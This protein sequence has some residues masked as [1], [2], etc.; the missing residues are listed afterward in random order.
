MNPLWVVNSGPGIAWNRRPTRNPTVRNNILRCDR[1]VPILRIDSLSTN[2]NG[3]GQLNRLKANPVQLP[4]VTRQRFM[5]AIPSPERAR[6]AGT[7]PPCY[8]T[9]RSITSSGWV[10]GRVH[11]RTAKIISLNKDTNISWKGLETQWLENPGGACGSPW[12]LH[13]SVVFFLYR[14]SPLM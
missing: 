9:F 6:V 2:W 12:I 3:L 13:Y 14:G 4:W 5:T 1:K 10:L 7:F 11:L 8:A